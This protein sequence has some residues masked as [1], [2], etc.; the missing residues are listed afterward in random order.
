MEPKIY[1]T[2]TVDNKYQII[3]NGMPITGK[4][5]ED[6]AVRI[7]KAQTYEP[8]YIWESK[9]SRFHIFQK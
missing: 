3:C 7:F 2:H 5:T 8:L 9:E 4:L 1:I 6:E